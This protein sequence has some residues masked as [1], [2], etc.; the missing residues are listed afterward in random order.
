[1]EE[2]AFATQK[3][4]L[5]FSRPEI[6]VDLASTLHCEIVGLTSD[7]VSMFLVRA[8]AFGREAARLGGYSAETVFLENAEDL[9]RTARPPGRRTG[10]PA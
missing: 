9:L 2:G 1:M 6:G 4:S 3:H 5:R 10:T 8:P 7:S